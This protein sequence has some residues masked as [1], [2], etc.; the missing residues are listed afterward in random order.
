MVLQDLWDEAISALLRAAL[1]YDPASGVAFST[2]ACHAV[3]RGCWRLIDPAHK[4]R[5]HYKNRRRDLRSL[6]EMGAWLHTPDE[7]TSPSAEDEA[8]AREAA[9]RAWLLREH[10][11]IASARGDTNTTTRLLE[12]ATVAETVAR[13]PRRHPR[14]TPRARA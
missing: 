14:I 5:R 2:Y 11:V 8:L 13:A 4:A 1:H 10:A 6:D 12:A 9:H 3:L 7:L